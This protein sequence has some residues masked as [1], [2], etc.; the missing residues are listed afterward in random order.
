VPDLLDGVERAISEIIRSGEPVDDAPLTL[1]SAAQAVARA[2]RELGNEGKADP[3]AP[4]V[5][6]FAQRLQRIVEAEAG[7]VPI[8][9]L[10]FDDGGPD[11]VEH[12]TVAGRARVLGQ[13]EL[14]AHGEHLRQA[15]DEIER[16]LSRTQLELRAQAL[17]ATFRALSAASGSPLHDAVSRFALAARE[18]VLGGAPV[19]NTPTFVGRLRDAGLALSETGQ[20]DDDRA[21]RLEEAA[22]ALEGLVAEPVAEAALATVE[23]TAEEQAFAEPEGEAEE[24]SDLAGSWARYERY[25]D[26][27][28]LGE[29]SLDELLAGPPADPGHAAPAIPEMP[30]AIPISPPVFESAEPEP[31]MPVAI[32]VSPPVFE[33]A[34]PEPEPVEEL[35]VPIADLCYSGTAA[36]D[37][38]ANLG[39]VIRAGLAAGKVS[40]D[41]RDLVEEVLDLVE[42]SRTD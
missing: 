41:L 3:E 33:S 21:V 37:R 42:L 36:L 18:A 17:V 16:A 23:E 8:E 19:T 2:A 30:V 12:G 7:V 31:E 9:S 6:D 24:T 39:E 15:A 29:P 14:V 13:V 25:V 32:P 26:S 20:D 34:E 27:L 28:G 1:N 38:A 35:I 10:Y 5:Q 11:I 22:T 4:E 40:S